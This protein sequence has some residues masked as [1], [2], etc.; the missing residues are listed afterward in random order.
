MKDVK[1][2]WKNFLFPPMI[3]TPEFEKDVRKYLDVKPEEFKSISDKNEKLRDLLILLA[4]RMEFVEHLELLRSYFSSKQFID[5][6]GRFFLP[7]KQILDEEFLSHHPEIETHDFAGLD[8]DIEALIVYLLITC[9]DTIVDYVYEVKG[10][11]RKGNENTFVKFFKKNISKD[12]KLQKE[13]I[14]CYVVIFLEDKDLSKEKEL[15]KEIDNWIDNWHKK[16]N[17]KKLE[18]IA[19]YLYEVRS[20]FTHRS[21][22]NFLPKQ[23][24]PSELLNSFLKEKQGKEKFFIL[25]KSDNNCNLG[26]SL[27]KSIKHFV[28]LVVLDKTTI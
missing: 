7:A 21:I 22:R 10:K 20:K 27:K 9:I 25:S 19:E 17:E 3:R 12:K 15:D 1:E 24:L 16:E 23:K 8:F 6:T 28:K 5:S 2:K 14:N 4:E 11:R 18:L 26:N 13:F